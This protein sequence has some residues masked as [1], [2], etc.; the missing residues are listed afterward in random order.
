M[1]RAAVLD[2]VK[3]E[4]RLRRR[5]RRDFPIDLSHA[6]DVEVFHAWPRSLQGVVDCSGEVLL[7]VINALV[8]PELPGARRSP[9]NSFDIR[10]PRRHGSTTPR[11]AA[12]LNNTSN[13]IL[14]KHIPSWTSC[15]PSPA[16]SPRW[17]RLE[18]VRQQAPRLRR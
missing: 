5:I 17:C 16:T 3:H 4:F 7:G 10:Q 18:T 14:C 2:M 1:P 9:D 15:R 11:R 6:I 12:Q 13:C 8:D